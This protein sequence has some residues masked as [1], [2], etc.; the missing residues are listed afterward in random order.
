METR[1]RFESVN[2]IKFNRYFQDEEDCYRYLSEIKWSSGDYH[3]K[4][5][6][7]I[8]YGKGKKPF[9]TMYEVQL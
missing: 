6:G 8:K 3:C 4:R 9:S 7:N 5:C 1:G 2:S